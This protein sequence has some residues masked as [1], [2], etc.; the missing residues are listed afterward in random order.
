MLTRRQW[1]AAAAVPQWPDIAT[2]KPDLVT[3]PMTL[4]DPR[5]GARARQTLD[6]WR[7]SGVYHALYLPPDW[8]PRKRLPVIVEYAGNGN[9]SN[10]YGDVSTGV[11]EGSHLGYGIS[12]G[13][14]FVW[15]C[16]P[17]IDS[18]SGRNQT[19]WWGDAD[20]TALYCRQAVQLVCG[21]YGGDPRRV[22]L[23]GFS[24]GAIACNYIGLRDGE[25]ARLW[26]AFV[27]YSHYDGV[28]TWPYAGSDRESALERLQR[29]GN[30]PQFICHEQSVEDTRR[31]LLS[32]GIQG[33]WDFHAVPFRNHN[34]RWVLRD[35]PLRRRLR[36]WIRD[37]I[38]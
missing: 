35:T 3:P 4:G 33:N 13:R 37:A 26:R 12:G 6:A 18:A 5:P 20:A 1:L 17:Y 34:D 28:R 38:G 22:V 36:R 24:R 16:V 21:E 7:G 31:Y 25:I 23:S 14:G 29:L 10:R 30:R 2:I 32:T 19:L 15:I 8:T 11:P 27:C 9:Y